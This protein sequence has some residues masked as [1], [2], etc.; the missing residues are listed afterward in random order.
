[1]KVAFKLNKKLTT[2]EEVML[3]DIIEAEGYKA[4]ISKEKTHILMD[5][6][7]IKINYLKNLIAEFQHNSNKNPAEAF[8]NWMDALGTNQEAIWGD[9]FK[10]PV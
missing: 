7:E 8:N 4:K 6:P 9:F 10:K 5:I 1:M 3:F 2:M